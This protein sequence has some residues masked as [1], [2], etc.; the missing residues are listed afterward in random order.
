[1]GDVSARSRHIR[2]AECPTPEED[3]RIDEAKRIVERRIGGRREARREARRFVGV[4]SV[5][6][7]LKKNQLVDRA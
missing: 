3:K 7:C 1:M 6:L 2:E 4:K 5:E